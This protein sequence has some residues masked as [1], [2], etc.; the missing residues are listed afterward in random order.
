MVWR[1]GSRATIR[2]GVT[3]S[4]VVGYDEDDVGFRLLRV[5]RTDKRKRYGQKQP[6]HK[7]AEKPEERGIILC[8]LLVIVES[9]PTSVSRLSLTSPRAR[10]RLVGFSPDDPW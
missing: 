9:V 3:V 1:L 4:E 2:A 6:A 10:S 5:S 8:H 7:S